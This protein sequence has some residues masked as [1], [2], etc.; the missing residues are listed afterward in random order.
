MREA[1]T[2]LTLFLKE[3][4]ESLNIS[5]CGPTGKLCHMTVSLL[6]VYLCGLDHTEEISISYEIPSH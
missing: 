5:I 4:S 6:N 2:L 3:M 1:A